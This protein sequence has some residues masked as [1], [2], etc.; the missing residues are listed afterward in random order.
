MNTRN[1]RKSTNSRKSR[2]SRKSKSSST[3]RKPKMPKERRVKKSQHLP[4][5]AKVLTRKVTE[6]GVFSR[7]NS[8]MS[9]ETLRIFAGTNGIPWGGLSKNKLIR[10]INNYY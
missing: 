4:R 9:L 6:R 1:S 5:T 2:K 10:K 7:A 8:N 3:T